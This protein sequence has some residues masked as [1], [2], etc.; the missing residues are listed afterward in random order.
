M[1]VSGPILVAHLF[2]EISKRLVNV[3][4]SLSPDDWHRQQSVHGEM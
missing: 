1:T 2:P 4:R 3:L